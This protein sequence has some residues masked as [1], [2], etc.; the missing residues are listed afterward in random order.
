LG[1]TLDECIGLS[2]KIIVMKD[3]LVGAEFDSPREH[4][5]SQVDI[6]RYM[7]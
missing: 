4:K 6:L 7:M 5:P 3:G 1:D 2:S